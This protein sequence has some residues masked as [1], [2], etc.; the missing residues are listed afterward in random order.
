MSTEKNVEFVK[1]LYAAFNRGDLP[2]ILERFA[3]EMEAF[4]V[5]AGGKAKAPW[6]F[7][8]KRREDVAKY[9]QQLLGALE[10]VALTPTHY[11]AADDYVYAT[12]DHAYKVRKNGK[13]L[14]FKNGF[15]RFKLRGGLVVE[16]IASED[17]Q[18]TIESLG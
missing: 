18:L 5:M 6:H 9:F 11:A 8:G 12:L 15:H 7:P 4:G 10:P 3:P 14:S 2:Y 13:T 1:D 17:T 16:W